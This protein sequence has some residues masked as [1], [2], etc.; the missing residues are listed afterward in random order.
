MQPAEIFCIIAL[1]E[2]IYRLPHSKHKAVVQH[3]RK[4]TS[5]SAVQHSFNSSTIS[6]YCTPNALHYSTVNIA[7]L[8]KVLNLADNWACCVFCLECKIPISC[9]FY[10]FFEHK[11]TH[12]YFSFVKILNFSGWFSDKCCV[13]AVSA[14]VS[15]LNCHLHGCWVNKFRFSIYKQ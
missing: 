11:E 2:L 3:Q 4:I 1:I 8:Y 7:E 14:T 10:Y 13:C 5:S 12:L 15:P 6:A 9:T